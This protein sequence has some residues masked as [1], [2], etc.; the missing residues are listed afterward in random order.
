ML[1]YRSISLKSENSNKLF[2]E[3]KPRAKNGAATSGIQKQLF[4]I[5]GNGNE[6]FNLILY[7]DAAPDYH[8]NLTTTKLDKV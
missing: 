8:Q 7:P 3:F 5:C 6:S 2:T 1:K 4:A